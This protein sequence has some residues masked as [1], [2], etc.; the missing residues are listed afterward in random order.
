MVCC[1][2]DVVVGTGRD[3]SSN[4]GR[5]LSSTV[6]RDLSSNVGGDLFIIQEITRRENQMV[7]SCQR[8]IVILGQVLQG[9]VAT[10]PY[11]NRR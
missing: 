5:D 3:L 8:I 9:Q 7:N 2:G 4:V 1:F 6:R 11:R 10:C